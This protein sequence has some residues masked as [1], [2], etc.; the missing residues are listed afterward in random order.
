LSTP[1]AVPDVV[2][3]RA[4]RD[5]AA[6]AALK[7]GGIT[8]AARMVH[9]MGRLGGTRVV[10]AADG[11]VALPDKLPGNVE[12]RR[13]AG[14]GEGDTAARLAA[15]AAELGQPPT[16]GADVVRARPLPVQDGIRVVDEATRRSAEDAVFADLLRGD[17]GLVARHINKKISFRITRDYLCRWPFTPNEVTLGAAALG[18]IGCLLI[19][20]GNYVGI[21][22]GFLL[23]Q[24]QSILDG[25]DGELARVRF[26]QSAVGEWLD[27]VVDDAL[28]LALVAA[29]G[30][31]LSRH[32][33]SGNDVWIALLACAMLL[34]YN[35]VAYRELIKQGEGGEV[36]KVRWWFARGRNLKAMQSE[37]GGLFAMLNVIG[38]RDFFVFAW[39]VMAVLDLLPVILL[40]AFIVALVYFVTAIG[41]ILSPRATS[42]S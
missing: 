13:L 29:I 27:T 26:Q 34:T 9:Q 14:E 15:V 30:V 4:T 28:N 5:E 33:G 22:L 7:V 17:L 38:K 3:V 6:G 16:T 21:V 36:L 1:T 32:G 41:Q 31:G 8:V 11:A 35:I 23:A 40:Y 19:A 24:L 39:L 42:Q 2:L 25:C 20:T 10:I 12:V 37:S 18:L